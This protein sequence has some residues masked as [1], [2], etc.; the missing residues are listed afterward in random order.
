MLE[1]VDCRVAI[2]NT[3]SSHVSVFVVAY[4]R[5]QTSYV[6]VEPK[7]RKS[8][9]PTQ[10][11]AGEAHASSEAA[12]SQQQQQQAESPAAAAAASPAPSVSSRG[13]R[14][15]SAG[16]ELRRSRIVITVKRTESYERWLEE[17]PL[18]A[19]IA[20]TGEDEEEE[21]AADS[22]AHEVIP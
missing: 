3:F 19:I 7:R 9:Q 4:S 6:A 5:V 13:G 14:G 18:Q 17:N 2:R 20:G 8:S 22:P 12:G 1:L 15:G 11:G 16:R 21:G 10:S